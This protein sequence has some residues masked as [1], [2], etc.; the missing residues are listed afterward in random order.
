MRP[1][2]PACCWWSSRSASIV[3]LQRGWGAGVIQPLIRGQSQVSDKH[4]NTSSFPS[5]LTCAARSAL[6][7]CTPHVLSYTFT[8]L[9][10]VPP[11]LPI[12][13]VAVRKQ[14]ASCLP[15]LFKMNI[16]RVTL[17]FVLLLGVALSSAP[18]CT[19]ATSIGDGC[20]SDYWACIRHRTWCSRCVRRC[21]LW[22]RGIGGGRARLYA[23]NCH[24]LAE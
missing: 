23:E 11:P 20:Y 13:R 6:C 1:G 9:C 10:Q 7:L 3:K 15:N 24:R 19:I 14:L 2:H 21:V 16:F 5:P 8:H 22:E 12:S 17:V 18:D 4:D